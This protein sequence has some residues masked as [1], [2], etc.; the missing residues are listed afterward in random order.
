MSIIQR[1]RSLTYSILRATERY[2]KTDMVYLAKGSFWLSAGKGVYMLTAFAL[3]IAFANLLVPDAYGTYKYIMAIVGVVT[4]AGLQSMGTAVTQA[5][6]RGFEATIKAALKFQIGFGTLSAMLCWIAAGYYF[7]RG[8]PGLAWAL[9][10]VSVFLP[11]DHAFDTYGNVLEGKKEFKLASKY[12][13]LTYLI[14]AV[15]LIVALFLTTNLLIIL[16]LTFLPRVVVNYFI[17]RRIL[18]RHLANEQVDRRAISYGIFLSVTNIISHIAE[19]I[20]KILLGH[21][22]GASAIAIYAFAQAPVNQLTGLGRMLPTLAFPKLS[23]QSED[24]IVQH[25]PAKLVRYFALL[26]P[27]TLVYVYLAPWLYK[28]LYPQYVGA[29][30]YS[31]VFALIILLLP[32]NLFSN[33]LIAKRRIREITALRFTAPTVRIVLLVVLIP[34]YGIW[35][36]VI[37]QVLGVLFNSLMVGALFTRMGGT[38][39]GLTT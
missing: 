18:R 8:D 20:D 25:L 9:V 6:A 32:T 27:L 17:L 11:F 28:L 13:M 10:V 38:T 39:S 26:L 31:Q 22:L 36:A 29:V 14:S 3:S 19:N 4:V 35:G 15:V 34:M 5:T 37:A 33:S 1:L 23:Q 21:F 30:G 7:W 16:T 2:T 24:E 12:G